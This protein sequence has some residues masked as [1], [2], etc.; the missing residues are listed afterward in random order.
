MDSS[1][2]EIGYIVVIEKKEYDLAKIP[3]FNDPLVQRENSRC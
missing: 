2:N 1:E 3:P